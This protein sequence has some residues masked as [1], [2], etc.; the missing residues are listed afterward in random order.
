MAGTPQSYRSNEAKELFKDPEWKIINGKTVKFSDVKVGELRM[1]DVEDPDLYI[2]QPLLEWQNSE[3]GSW[4]MEHAAEPPFWH[5]QLNPYTF[6]WTY[7]IIARLS[8]QDETYWT[9]KWKK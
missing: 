9:L 2:A 3:E 6:G 4:V 7:Y 5:R 8:E 1:G